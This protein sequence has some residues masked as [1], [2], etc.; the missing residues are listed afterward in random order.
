[1]LSGMDQKKPKRAATT[2]DSDKFIVR[3]PDG[4]RQR[5]IEAAAGNNRTMNAEVVARL[6][7]SFEGGEDAQRLR[8]LLDGERRFSA[9]LR[10][11]LMEMDARQNLPPVTM[12][13]L[14]DA[15]GRPISWVEIHAVHD[16][17]QRVTKERPG[18][19]ET[20]IVTPDVES[21]SKRAREAA[22]LALVLR[23]ME[24]VRLGL[25]EQGTEIPAFVR[26]SQPALSGSLDLGGG[27]L[28]LASGVNTVGGGEAGSESLVGLPVTI[29]GRAH[30]LKRDPA[31]G[32]LEAVP[33]VGKKNEQAVRRAAKKAAGTK[34]PAKKTAKG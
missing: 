29:R 14:L 13:I 7:A 24:P 30:T 15:S 33:V 2:N 20:F 1:M 9:R 23:S 8:E 26:K 22:D 5:I 34:P 27:S 3:M 6:Q 31:T 21:S 4:M 11:D 25:P 28:M 17:V 12:R 32:Q 16:A 19:W 10:A 18:S